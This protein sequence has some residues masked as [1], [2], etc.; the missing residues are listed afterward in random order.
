VGAVGD[1]VTGFWAGKRVLVTGGTGFLGR[2][3][4]PVLRETGCELLAPPR[5]IST[6]WSKPV[7]RLMAM[8]RPCRSIWPGWWEFGQQRGQPSSAMRIFDGRNGV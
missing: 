2:N 5:R 7:R 6:F 1:S 3:L 4:L 8:A